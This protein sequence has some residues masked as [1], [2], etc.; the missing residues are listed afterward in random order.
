[1]V[2][3]IRKDWVWSHLNDHYFESISP[4]SPTSSDQTEKEGLYNY[5]NVDKGPAI[6]ITDSK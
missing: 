2:T 3:S 1:M 4:S 6:I 5:Q